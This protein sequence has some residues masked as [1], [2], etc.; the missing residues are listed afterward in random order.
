MPEE[1]RQNI[2]SILTDAGIITETQLEEALE[3]QLRSGERLGLVLKG[4][5]HATEEDVLRALESQLGIPFIKLS[6]APVDSSVISKIPANFVYQHH[7]FPVS[8][9]DGVLTVA[10]SD[11]LDIHTLDDVRLLLGFDVQPVIASQEDIEKAIR[12]HY[13]VGADTMES[14]AQDRDELGIEAIDLD[15]SDEDLE[16]MADDA[17]IVKFV[18]QVILEA[19]HSR[20]TDI[21]IEPFEE[22]LRIRYRVDGILQEQR[23]PPI[24]KRFQAAII[25][26]LKIMADLNIAEKRLPQ[27]G[28]IRVRIAGEDLDLRISVIPTISGESISIRLL[29]GRSMFLQ[30]EQL[31]LDE[32]D[33]VQMK[34]LA[35]KPHGIVLVTGPTGCGKTTTLYAALSHINIAGTKIITIEDPV[36]YQM[37]GISQIQ[38][39][40]GIGLSFAQGLRSILRQDP[41][42]VMVGEIR[43]METAEIAIRAALT[44]HLVFSTLHTN[45]AAG[46]VTR[47]LDMG[48]EA[49]LVSASIEG[50]VAQRLVRT[51]CDSCKESYQPGEE[52]LLETGFPAGSAGTLYRGAGCEEC[53]QTGY[54]GR[55]ALYEI[56]VMDEPLRELIVQRSSASA[57]RE[58]AVRAG[59]KALRTVGWERVREGVTTTEEVLRVAEVG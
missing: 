37:Y 29:S 31:G 20:A 13:G 35:E 25:S 1:K 18:N 44:G 30:M 4:L 9:K 57:I 14:M 23:T 3:E 40:P 48:V 8:E 52:Y 55:T 54:R 16:K 32:A 33:L 49:F 36:E 39:R 19:F 15:A 53:N 38:V 5:G 45:D 59:M 24:V 2:G 7:I 51:I 50:L 21:H 47:L 41:D 42:V 56:L 22:N 10:M 12:Q 27:D 28:R 46:G 58:H 11:P 17:S 43:D 6:E 34:S 26:R